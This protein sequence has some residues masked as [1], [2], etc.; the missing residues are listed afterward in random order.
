VSLTA[1]ADLSPPP[2]EISR[3]SSLLVLFAVP[4]KTVDNGSR[5]T[6]ARV[7]HGM[8]GKDRNRREMH[9]GGFAFSA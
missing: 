1:S 9:R 2:I 8:G 6:T 7:V 5:S 3:I 4:E